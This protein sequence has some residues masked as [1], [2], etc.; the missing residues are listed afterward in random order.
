MNART[1]TGFDDAQLRSK[2]IDWLDGSKW[3]AV[4]SNMAPECD[5]ATHEPYRYA[6]WR[7][8]NPAAPR[9]I[10]IGLNPSTATEEKNDPTIKRCIA[11]AQRERCGGYIML[12]LFA[13]RSTDPKALYGADD[14]IGPA[15]DTIIDALVAAGGRTVAA[16]GRHGV[17]LNRDLAVRRRVR[18]LECFAINKDGTPGHPLYLP[19]MTPLSHYAPPT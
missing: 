14:P 12:N 16:W 10:V 6:L 4:Y 3:G 5:A 19:G 9:F 15:N 8:W 7:I 13:L 2:S 11:F 18:G 1:L 17:L